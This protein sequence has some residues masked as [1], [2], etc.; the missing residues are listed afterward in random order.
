MDPDEIALTNLVAESQGLEVPTSTPEPETTPEPA[1]PQPEE[2][3]TPPVAPEPEAPSTETPGAQ[4]TEPSQTPPEQ[5]PAIDWQALIPKRAPVAAPVPDENGE[6]DPTQLKEWLISEAVETLRTE[7]EAQQAITTGVQA[8]EAILP[9]MKD[10]PQVAS[11]MRDL[12]IAQLV[13][14]READMAEI[15][16]TVRGIIGEAKAAATE[17]ANASVTVQR[18]AAL[19]GGAA[20]PQ[21]T[22]K[23]DLAARINANEPDAFIELLDEWQKQGVV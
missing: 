12:T 6:V 21:D 5:A 8:A 7:S 3:P 4:P 20:Q 14:G 22:S 1:V 16:K 13:D 23:Q 19:E 17:N 15:A 18:N 2:T 10:N 11:L 9:E